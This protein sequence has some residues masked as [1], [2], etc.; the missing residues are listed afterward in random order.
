LVSYPACLAIGRALGRRRA[1]LRRSRWDVVRVA[2]DRL[3]GLLIAFLIALLVGFF[4]GLIGGRQ[5]EEQAAPSTPRTV[6]AQKN[7][8]ERTQ[9]EPLTGSEEDF[10][11]AQFDDPT[12]IDNKWLPLT[13]GTQLVY[14]GSAIV[15]EEGRQTRRVVT[16]VTDLSKVIDG[17]RTLVIWERDYT[18]GQ[19]SE[20]ELAFFAQDNTGNVWLVGEYPEEYENGKFDKAPAW[21]SGQK[22]ARAGITMLA[23]PQLGTPDYAQGFAPPP[24]DF[25]DRARV[26]K[27]GPKTCTPVECYQNVLVTEEFNPDEPGASQLKYYASGV[28]NVRVGWRGEK[29]QEK[30][31]LELVELNHLDPEALAKVRKKTLQM[32]GRAYERSEVYRETPKAKHTLRVGQ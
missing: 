26:Y 8:S 21:I 3:I 31:T 9:A 6:T 20:P 24:V 15:D 13:P 17:V 22:G 11:R 19:L 18:A 2:V 29:E 30:E 1:Y 23:E 28:G 16:T 27:I 14:E 10:D 5:Q 32:D 25:T 12:H 4:V 7:G